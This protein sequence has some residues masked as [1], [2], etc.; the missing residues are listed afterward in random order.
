MEWIRPKKPALSIDMAPMIDIVFQL[1][2]FFMLSS[3]FLTPSIKM[4]LPQADS[5]Q[6]P[7]NQQIIVSIDQAGRFFVNQT[8]TAEASLRSALEPLLAASEKKSVFVRGDAEMPYK[9]FV[10][11]MDTERFK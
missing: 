2:I 7:E 1:L 8:E 11:V 3:S 6:A 10:A 4:N 9:H 5:K